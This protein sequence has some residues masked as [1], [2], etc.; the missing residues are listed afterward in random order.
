MPKT[1]RPQNRC[2]SCGYTWHPRGKNLSSKC[3]S[4]GHK[5]V[6]LAGT[7]AA[8]VIGLAGWAAVSGLSTPSKPAVPRSTTVVPV[9][10]AQNSEQAAVDQDISLHTD[11]PVQAAPVAPESVDLF[12]WVD[13]Q[14]RSEFPVEA[15]IS[16]PRGRVVLQAGPSMMSRN[17]STIA[18]GSPVLAKRGEGKWIQIYSPVGIGYVQH[19]ELAFPE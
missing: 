16:E 1:L 13:P 2:T 7:V 3:P 14:L 10:V 8:A 17:M 11:E 19:K 5:G 15:R 12:A 9:V 18:N 4:C 6:K